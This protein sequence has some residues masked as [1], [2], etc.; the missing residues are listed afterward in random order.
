MSLYPL[1]KTE[2]LIIWKYPNP[3]FTELVIETTDLL[4]KDRDKP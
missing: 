4:F 1:Q 2:A 3:L